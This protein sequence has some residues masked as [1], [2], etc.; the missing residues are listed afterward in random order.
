[1]RHILKETNRQIEEHEGSHG[2][3]YSFSYVDLQCTKCGEVVEARV[4]ASDSKTLTERMRRREVEHN[5]DKLFEALEALA[6]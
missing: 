3:G 5:L 2:H 4:F 1:M 6:R